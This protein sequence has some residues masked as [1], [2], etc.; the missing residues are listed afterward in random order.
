MDVLNYP[1][2]SVHILQNKKSLRRQLL[3]NKTLL[4]KRIA[5]LSG[6]TVGDIKNILEI[7]LLK[8][9][10]KPEFYIGQYDR[11]YEE[12]AFENSELEEF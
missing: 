3:Q 11:F 6:S 2:D 10:I 5:I 9:G 1:F 7:F 4:I 12:V 8:H